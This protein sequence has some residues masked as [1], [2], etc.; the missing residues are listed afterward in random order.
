[1]QSILIKDFDHF[2]D[3]GANLTPFGKGE[4]ETDIIWQN[5]MPILKGDEWRH[6]RWNNFDRHQLIM[7]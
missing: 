7:M 3:R 5:V 1:M 2:V 4:S 6:N